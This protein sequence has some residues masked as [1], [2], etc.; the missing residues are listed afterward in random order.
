MKHDGGVLTNDAQVVVDNMAPKVKIVHPAK[1]AEG[2]DAE[3]VMEDAEMV[4]ITAD[5]EDTW[6]MGKVEFYLD[7]TKLGE[8]TVAPY[9]IRWTITMASA[10]PTAVETHKVT[11]KAYDRAGNMAESEPVEFKV[12][13]KPK[14]TPKPVGL[15]S[16]GREVAAAITPQAGAAQVTSPYADAHAADL[17]VRSRPRLGV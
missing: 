8:T 13:H 15:D 6:A 17:P 12:K 9:S 11:A 14:P 2:K 7:G 10:S 5:A 3:Y 16:D 4:S 1:D